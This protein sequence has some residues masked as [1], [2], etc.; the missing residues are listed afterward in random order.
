MRIDIFMDI[1][2]ICKLICMYVYLYMCM[3][4]HARSVPQRDRQDKQRQREERDSRMRVTPNEGPELG[5]GNEAREVEHLSFG[6]SP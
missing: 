1:H 3:Y 4:I 2:S 5:D 6:I